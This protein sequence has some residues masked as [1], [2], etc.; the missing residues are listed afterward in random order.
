[1]YFEQIKEFELLRRKVRAEEY[2]MNT[3]K[4][5]SDKETVKESKIKPTEKGQE[6]TIKGIQQQPIQLDPTMKM[7]Q[8]LTKRLERIEKAVSYRRYN[9]WTKNSDQ[10]GKNQ[11]QNLQSAQSRT[12]PKT[13][14]KNDIN[15]SKPLNQ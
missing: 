10:T 2:E 14:E 12:D 1:M 13:T 5:V 6:T 3:T 4:T 7:M 8:D 11:S 9:R 15:S